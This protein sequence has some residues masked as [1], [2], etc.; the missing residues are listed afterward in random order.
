MIT[1]GMSNQGLQGLY[2]RVL[3]RDLCTLCGACLSLCP[4]LRAHHGRV[5]KLHDCD[6]ERGSCFARCPRTAPEWPAEGEIGRVERVLAAR[7]TDEAVRG[8]AQNGGVVSAL[9]ALALREGQISA[10]LLTG[11]DEGYLPATRVARILDQV[12]ACAGTSYVG[13]P[14][15]EALGSD[16]LG[17]ADSVGVVGLPCQVQALERI[18]TSWETPSHRVALVI[19]LFCTW[20][21]LPEPFSRFFGQRLAGRAVRRLEITPPPGRQLI[22]FTDRGQIAVPLDEIRPFIRPGCRACA[23][24]TSELADL[25][26][27]SVEDRP[28]WNTVI[29]RTERG[30]DLVELA[31]RSKQIE[32]EPL[33]DENLAHL[34]Q[35]SL[36]KRRRALEEVR[37]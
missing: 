22:A 4:Y 12:L 36:A 25:S 8:R 13:A 26:V 32:Q 14:T 16:Q 33:P 17:P 7:A 3:Q 5:V 10:A 23:D 35:A 1:A 37:K 18:R 6:L 15:L 21:L 27:G 29:V 9:V 19:G 28:G 11:R 20:A 31:L 34:K 24:L 2:E 30:R